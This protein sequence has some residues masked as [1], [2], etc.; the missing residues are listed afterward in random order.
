MPGRDD[1]HDSSSDLLYFNGIDGATGAYGLPPMSGA[2]LA[3]KLRGEAAPENL[4]ELKQRNAAGLAHYGVKEGI[5][6]K[7][8]DQAG[9]GVVFAHGADP[10]VREALAPLLDW[11]RAEAGERFRLYDGAA[12]LRPGDSKQ[13]FLARHGA[14]PGPADPAK[15]PYYLLLVGDPEAIPY[16][17]QSQ[18][19]VQY[20]VGRIAFDRL[21]DYDRYARSVVAA[22]NGEARRARR[23]SFFGVTNSDDPATALAEEKLVRPLAEQLRG[24][25]PDWA[26]D[27][28]LRSAAHK[29]GL[30]RLLSGSGERPALL[31]SA[32]HGM[33]F[34]LGD[35]RQRAHQGALLCGDWPGP[36]EWRGAIP[37]DFYFAA[38]DLAAGAD[39]FGLIGFFFACYGLGTPRLDEFVKQAFREQRQEIAPHSFLA[40]LPQRMLA[41]PGG[42]ALAVVG[43]VERAWGTSFVWQG[44]GAQTAVFESTLERLLD[45]HPIGSALEFF[46]ERYAELSTVLADQLEEIEFG[47]EADPYE[48]AGLWTANND[49]RG[50]ALMGDPAVRLAIAGPEGG[51]AKGASPQVLGERR[52]GPDGLSLD[53][54][55]GRG[56]ERAEADSRP[57]PAPPSPDD[58]WDMRYGSRGSDDE[59]LGYP[60]AAPP[61]R[62]PSPGGGLDMGP[63]LGAAPVAESGGDELHFSAYPPRCLRAGETKT[64]WV[65]VHLEEVLAAVEK[66]A[67]M[68]LGKEAANQPRHAAKSATRVRPGT[69]ILLAPQVEGLAFDPPEAIVEWAPPSQKTRFEVKAAGARSGHVA[70]GSIACYV[71]PLL[72]ADLPLQILAL[73]AAA[74]E[75]SGPP[76]EPATAKAYQAIFASYSHQ[77]TALV[78]AMEKAYEALGMDYLR[79]VMML[80][81]GQ[82]WSQTLLD[83]ID[84]ADIFQLFWSQ[85]AAKSIYV[86]QEWRRALKVAPRKGGAFIRPIYW[87]HPLPKVPREL[88]RCHFAPVELSPLGAL[89]PAAQTPTPAAALPV[90]IKTI[91]TYAGGNPDDPATRRLM[92]STEISPGGDLETWFA[93]DA[94]E[95]LVARH[96]R[97]V[98]AALASRGRGN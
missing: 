92:A 16:R 31:F 12:A 33:E 79:D 75:A 90:T 25:H 74:E 28:L 55:S 91:K 97:A 2:D 45:G 36:K 60:P 52:G 84:Q 69:E 23:A 88:S 13:R 98:N 65:F 27:Q 57:A 76:P 96:E 20:A 67:R 44:A 42:G 89:I 29:N 19:D 68:L 85:E 9:W 43:H 51:A 26:I 47:A 6:P 14:G 5:D 48:L 41:H 49:A 38:D 35:A 81:S 50:Y 87:E 46:N 54:R 59:L 56:W 39:L 86:E 95:A 78:K 18:L 24:R 22:E 21:E 3:R 82:D 11:R 70:T 80:K 10:A 73:E 8:L 17:F 53:S 15:V 1:R 34:P 40:A 4:A 62:P 63:A 66:E 7:R 94:G 61:I 71:G 32:S 37:Q 83:K 64:L 30:E 77:D 58:G 93:D 72:I